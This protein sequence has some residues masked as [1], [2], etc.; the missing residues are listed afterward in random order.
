MAQRLPGRVEPK[1]E[2]LNNSNDAVLRLKN[3]K[4]KK[5]YEK[6]SFFKRSEVRCSIYPSTLPGV[7]GPV[8]ELAPCVQAW[9]I[10]IS[11]IAKHYYH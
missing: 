3:E 9:T 4:A 8:V 11:Y 10:V 2:T 6:R 5:K 7:R 1:Q